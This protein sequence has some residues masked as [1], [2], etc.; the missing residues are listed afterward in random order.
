MA[1]ELVETNGIVPMAFIGEIPWHGLGQK[2]EENASLEVWAKQAGMDFEILSSNLSYRANKPDSPR[3]LHSFPNRI[4]LYREDN[5]KPLS[6]VSNHYKLV[7]PAQILNFFK[8]LIETAG[9]KMNTAGVLFGGKK[10]WALV[11]IGKEANI[12]GNDLVKGF[13]LLATSCD[14][15]LA[16]TA[17]FTS[18]RVVCNNTLEFAVLQENKENQ[19]QVKVPHNKIFN[20]DEIKETLGLAGDSFDGFTKQ[21]D[22]MAK[23]VIKDKEA[24]QWLVKVFSAGDEKGN[25]EKEKDISPAK[26]RHIKNCFDLYKGQGKGSNLKSAKDTVWGVVNAV[27]EYVDFHKTSKSVDHR[28]NNSWFD[29]TRLLKNKAY[30]EAVILADTP[31][32]RTLEMA[33]LPDNILKDGG[34]VVDWI[35]N[36]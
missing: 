10:F 12:R 8:G 14:G 18:I 29:A 4:A 28:I 26:A 9:F 24:V 25:L 30:E 34:S 22:K 2:M 13:V 36:S 17:S 35:L 23:R 27:T 33:N 7:Q 11:E 32:E 16:T 19:N 3:K 15:S 5:G 6:I 20:P 31:M 21:A 1:H